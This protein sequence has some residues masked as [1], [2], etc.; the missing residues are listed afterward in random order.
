MFYVC[1]HSDS[2][3]KLFTLIQVENYIIVTSNRLRRQTRTQDTK[4]PDENYCEANQNI[5]RI[6]CHCRLL[7]IYI[8]KTISQ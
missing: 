3:G 4:T 6:R 1:V 5:D 2:R 7:N 8:P